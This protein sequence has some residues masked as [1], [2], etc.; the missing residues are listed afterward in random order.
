MNR[1][2]FFRSILAIPLS[3]GLAPATGDAPLAAS[4]DPAP[5]PPHFWKSRQPTRTFATFTTLGSNATASFR[6]GR[7]ADDIRG[8]TTSLHV[9]CS[10]VNGL[11]ASHLLESIADVRSRQAG[12]VILLSAYDFS[13]YVRRAAKDG[14]LDRLRAL[15]RSGDVLLLDDIQY[16]CKKEND[17]ARA[18]LVE[19]LRYY[20]AAYRQVVLTT[21][22]AGLKASARMLDALPGVDVHWIYRPDLRERMILLNA[23]SRRDGTP[24]PTRSRRVS[25]PCAPTTFGSLRASSAVSASLRNSSKS[26]SARTGLWRSSRRNIPR[27]GRTGS[28]RAARPGIWPPGAPCRLSLDTQ[29]AAQ[30]PRQ[31]VARCGGP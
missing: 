19:L 26:R 18:E 2:A 14:T 11:G 8:D 9:L 24:L 30:A 12:R 25:P 5:E 1:R 23:M 15:M 3:A 28:W 27:P 7:I 10:E 17:Q 21:D 22:G 4:S 29:R 6:A 13:G 20:H 31:R 16:L